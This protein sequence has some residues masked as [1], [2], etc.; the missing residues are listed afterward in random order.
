LPAD[1]DDARDAL[2][3]V[4]LCAETQRVEV[5]CSGGRGRTGTAL[6]CLAIL[7]GIADSEAVDYVRARYDARAVET[8]WQRR[9]VARFRGRLTASR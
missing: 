1:P 8:R 4:W 3:E 7:D 9:F 5:V 2:I 6:A